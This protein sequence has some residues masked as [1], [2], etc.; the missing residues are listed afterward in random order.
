[1]GSGIVLYEGP[2]LIDGTPIVAIATVGSSNPKTGPMIQTWIL[3][4]DIS[5][6]EAAKN[7]QDR[8]IC[9]DCQHRRD[10]KTGART[11]YVQPYQA[12]RS[13]WS[14]FHRC[15][16][17]DDLSLLP[18]LPLRIGSYG[19]PLAVPSTIWRDTLARTGQGHT[20]Y[21]SQWQQ[22]RA[23]NMRDLLMASVASP[24]ERDR[25]Q[26]MGW[27]TFRPVPVGDTSAHPTEVQCPA[28][29]QGPICLACQLCDGAR[30]GSCRSI[31][32]PVHGTQAKHFKILD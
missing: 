9:G 8:A 28:I 18:S 6:I 1:M 13:V 30:K 17:S 11:C 25:A 10:P 20:G 4:R 5:P 21:T 2:S 16:Y 27:R 12:P 7:G 26:A 32:V 19:D 22:P 14:K 29:G 15:G 23:Q 31:T 3:A 24:L